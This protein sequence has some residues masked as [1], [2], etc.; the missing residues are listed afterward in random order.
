MRNIWA[1][2][3]LKRSLTSSRMA[4]NVLRIPF[5]LASSCTHCQVLPYLRNGDFHEARCRGDHRLESMRHLRFVAAIFL[6][7]NFCVFARNYLC[8]ASAFCPLIVLS[9]RLASRTNENNIHQVNRWRSFVADSEKCL[10]MHHIQAIKTTLHKR[11][12]NLWI[13]ALVSS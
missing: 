13:I 4:S 3:F 2:I 12:Y 11:E 7:N 1:F 5:M 10:H 9:F 8:F 6:S